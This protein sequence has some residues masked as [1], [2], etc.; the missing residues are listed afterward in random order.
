MICLIFQWSTSAN[1]IF[2]VKSFWYVL[3]ENVARYVS[4]IPFISDSVTFPG[5]CDIWSTCDVSIT[6]NNDIMSRRSTETFYSLVIIFYTTVLCLLDV[7]ITQVMF[8][9]INNEL[10]FACFARKTHYCDRY[11]I[12]SNS[13]IICKTI[14][15]VRG[16][17][18]R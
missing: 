11:S 10:R 5:M 4:L 16:M 15:Y 8:W 17:C 7:L 14:R 2:T 13:Q 1:R 18:V 3:Q 6:L 12:L 9:N